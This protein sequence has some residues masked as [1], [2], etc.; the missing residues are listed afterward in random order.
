MITLEAADALE[1]YRE[2]GYL[3]ERGVFAASEIEAIRA[4]A[5]A[6]LRAETGPISAGGRV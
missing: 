2:D 1:R 3:I 4:E 6:F 5:V